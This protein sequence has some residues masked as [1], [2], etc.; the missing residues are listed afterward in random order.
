MEVWEVGMEEEDIIEIDDKVTSI[1]QVGKNRVHKGLKGGRGV[2]ETKGHDEQFKEAK[3]AFK[4]G[5][6]FIAGFDTNVIVAPADIKFGEV[7]HAL[8]F[9]NEVRDEWEWGGIFNS[10]VV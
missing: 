3:G 7:V 10:D 8:E 2:A 4:G 1:N 9:I 6:P 5:F